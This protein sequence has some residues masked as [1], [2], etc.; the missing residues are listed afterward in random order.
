MI[1]TVLCGYG[2]MGKRMKQAI[3]E[4]DDMELMTVI[5]R[6]HEAKLYR[7]HRPADLLIDFSHP[8]GFDI[9]LR[10]V[11]YSG[12][13][14]LSGTTNLYPYQ[15]E[16]MQYLSRY[17]RVMYAVNY[18]LGIA[19]MQAMVQMVTP[20]LQ[21]DFDMD[22]IEAHHAQKQDTPSGTAKALLQTMEQ[23]MVNTGSHDRRRNIDVHAIRGGSIAGE[24]SVLY[25]GDEEKLEIKHTAMSRKLFVNGAMKAAHWLMKQDIGYYSISDM[26]GGKKHAK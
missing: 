19:L 23:S 10:Y 22:I 16:T 15:I 26:I 7:L 13:A 2:H 25:L 6:M 21:D 3:C 24:H 18:S 1:H 14:L 4:Q 11:K 5:D 12:C 20:C 8:D 17:T 9:A